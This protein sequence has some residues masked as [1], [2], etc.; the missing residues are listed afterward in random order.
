MALYVKFEK[1]RTIKE[2]LIK[3]YTSKNYDYSDSSLAASN[4]YDDPEC[5]ILQCER[6]ARSFDE[7][8][9][10][11]KTYYPSTTPK[12]LVYHLLTVVYHN[13]KGNLMYP[14]LGTC[15]GMNRIKYVPYYDKTAVTSAYFTAKMRESKYTW[16][17]LL[18]LHNIKTLADLRKFINY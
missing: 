13:R 9:E 4:T 6:H 1:P 11:V 5:K 14:Y 10:I 7:L 2:F 18:K 12:I 15:S 17:E 16:G 3:F 8:L